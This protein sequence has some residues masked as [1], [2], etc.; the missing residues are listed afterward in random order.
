MAAAWDSTQ[1]VSDDDGD[2]Q[3]AAASAMDFYDEVNA[4]STAPQDAASA[5]A[6]L[7][8]MLDNGLDVSESEQ[9]MRENDRLNFEAMIRT[10]GM[11]QHV[12]AA[13]PVYLH[14]RRNHQQERVTAGTRHISIMSMNYADKQ[15]GFAGESTLG[16]ELAELLRPVD[17]LT[18]PSV[19]LELAGDLQIG[20]FREFAFASHIRHISVIGNSFVEVLDFSNLDPSVMVEVRDCPNLTRVRSTGFCN[21][22]GCRPGVV[23]TINRMPFCEE[24]RALNLSVEHEGELRRWMAQSYTTAFG[25][26]KVR[27]RSYFDPVQDIIEIFPTDD[28]DEDGEAFDNALARIATMY[29]EKKKRTLRLTNR[30]RIG[31]LATI[32]AVFHDWSIVVTNNID[33]KLVDTRNTGVGDVTIRLCEQLRYVVASYDMLFTAKDCH[34]LGCIV[35]PPIN[36]VSLRA[37]SCARL[38]GIVDVHRVECEMCPV[39]TQL[40]R[41]VGPGSRIVVGPMCPLVQ[42]P[43][44]EENPVFWPEALQADYLVQ[45]PGPLDGPDLPRWAQIENRVVGDC[46]TLEQRIARRN[47]IFALLGQVGR[48]SA[49][50]YVYDETALIPLVIFGSREIATFAARGRGIA[51]AAAQDAQQMDGNVVTTTLGVA[52]ARELAAFEQRQR[53]RGLA[54][55]A[56]LRRRNGAVSASSTSAASA[57]SAAPLP[58]T[59]PEI[60][61][62]ILRFLL[63]PPDRPN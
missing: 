63:N 45:H 52:M 59:P 14:V 24:S 15:F 2:M 44:I 6:D 13:Q 17:W 55:I 48:G 40:P 47:E 58:Y 35:S 36:D 30:L 62:H 34:N 12:N 38:T 43:K 28:D 42:P 9:Q 46:D 37:Y 49:G 3:F 51:M 32:C 19:K 41:K 5:T 54:V 27:C 25:N 31:L 33:L 20:C 29:T 60:E 1:L 57:A 23:C 16:H 39:L 4:E 61:R 10:P 56:S 18:E 26:Q 11:Y 8:T 22:Y 50:S 53:E 21:L 7:E